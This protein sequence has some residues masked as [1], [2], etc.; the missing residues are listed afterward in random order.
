MA[1][2]A[3]ESA[4]PGRSSASPSPLA[5]C[6]PQAD[7]L[8]LA[9]D[10]SY[11]PNTHRT[12]CLRPAPS[13]MQAAQAQ[14]APA[15]PPPSCDPEL[16]CDRLHGSHSCSAP[17]PSLALGL[18]PGAWQAATRVH[19][20]RAASVPT[21]APATR[22]PQ[23]PARLRSRRPSKC[24]VAFPQGPAEP[25]QPLRWQADARERRCAGNTSAVRAAEQHG[26]CSG[27]HSAK[28]RAQAS[29]AVILAKTGAWL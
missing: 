23:P 16:D 27:Q 11:R 7:D 2:S 22:E 19:G 29:S 5:K 18:S 10:S 24:C 8:P 1:G 13:S 6:C 21:G 28:Q 4:L 12:S 17:A 3:R 9:E 25:W 26:G 14:V 20:S 15:P